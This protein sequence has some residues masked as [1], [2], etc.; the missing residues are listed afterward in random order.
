MRGWRTVPTSLVCVG[1]GL[2]ALVCVYDHLSSWKRCKEGASGCEKRATKRDAQLCCAPAVDC[3]HTTSH[4]SNT[5]VRRNDGRTE[6]WSVRV[7]LTAASTAPYF[8][9]ERPCWMAGR[10]YQ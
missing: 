10:E 4:M 8:Q 9:L 7:T 6:W 2:V 5:K 3:T 1:H